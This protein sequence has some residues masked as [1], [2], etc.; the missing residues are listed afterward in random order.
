MG[1]SDDGKYIATAEVNFFTTMRPNTSFVVRNNV[2]N[3][4]LSPS[5]DGNCTT[6]AFIRAKGK[7]AAEAQEMVERVLINS[8]SSDDSSSLSVVKPDDNHWKEL[9]VDFYIMVPSGTRL[10]VKT[11]MGSIELLNLEGQIKA[12]TN[13]GSIKAVETHGDAELTTNMGGI[14]F[15][16]SRD[17]SAKFKVHTNMGK[18]DSELPLN[19]D[20]SDMIKRNAQGIL[21]DGRD[22]IR[23]TT[24]MGKIDIKWSTD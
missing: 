9:N 23:L 18:I 15:V 20:T 1:K 3:I 11:N 5:K 6:R 17:I 7:T 8:H 2:G 16:A 13:M 24:N 19:I 10:D 14:D 12:V 21:G 22:S 4:S